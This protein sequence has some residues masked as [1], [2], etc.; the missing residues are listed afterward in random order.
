VRYFL[1]AI[2]CLIF[3][4]ARALADQTAPV[5]YLSLPNQFPDQNYEPLL[6]R[7]LARQSLLI[8]A[9]DGIGLDT[10]DALLREWQ[11]DTA[12]N[13]PADALS[14]PALSVDLSYAA[15]TQFMQLVL[16]TAGPSPRQ[17]LAERVPA[18]HQWNAWISI[19]KAV[20]DLE[21]PSRGDF[22]DK[23]KALGYMPRIAPA[24]N[25]DIPDGVDNLLY[26]TTLFSPYSALQQ[27]HAAIRQSGESPQRISALVRGYANLAELTAFQWSSISKVMQARSL[28]YAQRMVNH[29][30][31]SPF[32]YYNRAYAFA[33]CGLQAAAL[34]DLD[35]AHQ[36]EKDLDDSLQPVQPVPHWEPLLEPFCKY[37][38]QELA[39]LAHAGDISAP[40]VSF[41]VFLDTEHCGSLS[42]IMSVGNSALELNGSCFRILDVIT[43]NAGVISGHEFTERSPQVMLD[44]LPAEIK[45]LK[46]IPLATQNAL[47]NARGSA[48]HT[49]NLLAVTQSFLTATESA[50]PSFALA[51]RLVQETTFIHVLRRVDLWRTNGMWTA[52]TI[53]I[54]P[55]RL[56][57]I[58]PIKVT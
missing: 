51:G 25:L 1:I 17:I 7:E 28:L 16:S 12:G 31:D 48:D 36:L 53:W 37:D 58:I 6:M 52:R 32:S 19:P 21:P 22:I 38:L 5:V 18:F 44:T 54:K 14:K 8:A 30:P 26:Q 29:D 20:E 57:R 56:L 41:L 50:E 49:A 34:T 33:F 40:L 55:R 47:S 4:R 43:T 35:H 10:R 9:R 39:K 45:L 13:P 24:G 23:L 2:F 42:Q 46:R 27:V 3:S 15:D 11:P